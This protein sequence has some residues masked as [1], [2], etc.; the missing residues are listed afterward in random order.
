VFV[1]RLRAIDAGETL[2][3]Y[4]SAAGLSQM[5]LAVQVGVTLP[6]VSGWERNLYRPR[7]PTAQRLDD[8]LRGAGAILASFGYAPLPGSAEQAPYSTDSDNRVQRLEQIVAELSD[9]LDRVQGAIENPPRAEPH[10]SSR[11]G[12]GAESA[13]VGRTLTL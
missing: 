9:R 6:A 10:E 8:A 13:S 5:A 12:V 7:R 1:N 11:P 2:K 3:R 4:R